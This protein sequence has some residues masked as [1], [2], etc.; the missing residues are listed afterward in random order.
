MHVHD[1]RFIA[2][3]TAAKFSI[4]ARRV[5]PGTQAVPIGRGPAILFVLPGRKVKDYSL[6]SCCWLVGVGEFLL[7]P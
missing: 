7:L 2:R 6:L 3:F 1:V 5:R 4:A